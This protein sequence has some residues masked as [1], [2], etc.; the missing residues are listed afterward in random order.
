MSGPHNLTAVVITHERNS[1]P[2]WTTGPKTAVKS[3]EP[4]KNT[5][6]AQKE[7]V[8]KVDQLKAPRTDAPDNELKIGTRLQS[9]ADG[10]KAAPALVGGAP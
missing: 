9:L 8:D 6:E 5:C 3:V 2:V 4:L 1:G 7:L 10:L